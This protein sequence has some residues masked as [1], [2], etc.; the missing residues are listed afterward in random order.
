MLGRLYRRLHTHQTHDPDQGIRRTHPPHQTRGG[1]TLNDIGRSRCPTSASEPSPASSSRSATPP[2]SSPRRTWPPTPAPPV[3]RSSGSSIKGEHPA[4]TGNRKLKRV[5]PRRGQKHNA[6]LICLARHRCDVLYAMLRNKDL[7]PTSSPTNRLTGSIGHF[8]GLVLSHFSHEERPHTWLGCG[9]R[10]FLAV[11][12]AGPRTWSN[13]RRWACAFPLGVTWFHRT[14]PA[15]RLAWPDRPAASGP[16]SACPEQAGFWSGHNR[17]TIISD[18][19]VHRLEYQE[20]TKVVY[21]LGKFFRLAC[22]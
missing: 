15:V 19:W 8:G 22:W 21:Q 3:T 13:A 6:A 16:Q 20:A 9:P 12:P 17:W 10:P 11:F 7:L 14:A 4:R 1:L 5:L 18:H 2:T